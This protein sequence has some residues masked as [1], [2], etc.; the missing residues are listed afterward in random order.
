MDWRIALPGETPAERHFF[1]Q[2]LRLVGVN[3]RAA[4]AGVEQAGYIER[5]VTHHL[6]GQTETRPPRQQPVLGIALGHLLGLARRLPVG[7]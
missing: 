6:G 4:D 5:V 7:R 1:P 3:A 2:T